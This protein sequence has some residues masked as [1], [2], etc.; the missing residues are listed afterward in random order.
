MQ[1]ISN[2]AIRVE[3]TCIRRMVFSIIPKDAKHTRPS[4]QLFVQTYDGDPNDD[5]YVDVHTF[6]GKGDTPIGGFLRFTN[7]TK[8]WLEYAPTR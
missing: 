8:T 3:A 7:F 6:R 1:H 2:I 5:T 4:R